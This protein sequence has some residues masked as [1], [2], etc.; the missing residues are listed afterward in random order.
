[1]DTT[2]R[3]T[4]IGRRAH[5]GIPPPVVPAVTPAIH[6]MAATRPDPSTP[7]PS[8][9]RR[10]SRA[11]ADWPITVAMDDGQHE[12]RIRDVS[13]AGVC[14]FLDRPINEM[15]LLQVAF[16]LPVADGVRRISAKGAVVRCERISAALD[17]Y[18]IA[19]FLHEIA[20]PDQRTI[21]EY[22]T[23]RASRGADPLGS[24]RAGGE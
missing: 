24:A 22:V 23:R 16:E 7:R 2:A 14:F 12:A 21:G 5:P 19:V 1:M 13:R 17:H 6:A 18:E 10:W 8:E 20:E 11:R 3:D 9:R 15:T 4:R